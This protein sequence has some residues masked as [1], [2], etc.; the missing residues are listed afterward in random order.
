M[1]YHKERD[2]E[3]S[4]KGERKDG[5]INQINMFSCLTKL[6]STVA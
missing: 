2:A 4:L 1:R 3:K 5:K 6:G